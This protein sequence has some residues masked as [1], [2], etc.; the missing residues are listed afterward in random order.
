SD[1]A[2]LKI[3]ANDLKPI[4]IGNASAIRKGQFVI[5]LGNPYQIARDGTASASWGIVGNLVRQAE[6]DPDVP[7]RERPQKRL[8][9]QGM[10]IQID[11]RLD[12]GTS[13]GALIDLHGNLVGITTSLASIVGYEKSAGYAVPIDDSTRRIIEALRQGRE[14]E[15]GFLGVD[16]HNDL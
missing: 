7:L 12:L 8:Q 9:N 5:A 6:L 14:V 2:V 16:M 13:G 4:R 15:Y 1:L 11:T 3:A 10:L